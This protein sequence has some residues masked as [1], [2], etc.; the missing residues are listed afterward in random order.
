MG[1]MLSTW[2]KG[3]KRESR[4]QSR[5][6]PFERTRMLRTTGWRR[7]TRVRISKYVLYLRGY[8]V[9]KAFDWSLETSLK[10]IS[11]SCG[12]LWRSYTSKTNKIVVAFSASAACRLS[13]FADSVT[14]DIRLLDLKTRLRL[15]REGL[16][17]W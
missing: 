4:P 15:I 13:P 11:W 9:E 6:S 7:P 10:N 1:S 3:G 5:E 12:R 14:S 16:G 17:S 8:I 2:R